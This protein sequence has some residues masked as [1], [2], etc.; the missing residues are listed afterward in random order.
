MSENEFFFKYLHENFLCLRFVLVPVSM[1]GQQGL[2]AIPA[3]IG[4]AG[5]GT[6]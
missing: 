6:Q 5:S 1:R 2:E 4:F 3:C